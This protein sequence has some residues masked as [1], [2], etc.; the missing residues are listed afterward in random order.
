MAK[1]KRKVVIDQ[2]YEVVAVDQLLE[3]PQ[4]PRRGVEE[5]ISESITENGWY[6]A[7]IAQKSTGCILAGN[8]RFRVAVKRGAKEIPVIWRDVDDETATRIMLADNK[9]ADL[10]TYDEET[11]TTLLEGLETLDGT[12]YG[13]D[14]VQEAEESPP[15]ADGDGEVPEDKYAPSWGVIVVC[16]DEAHQEKVYEE[17]LEAGHQVRVVAV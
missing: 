10:G 4:N 6:G 1:Y 17:L 16:E 14:L 11:L 15:A 7:V 9:T 3:H 5:A 13:L 12:G 8:H 2:E